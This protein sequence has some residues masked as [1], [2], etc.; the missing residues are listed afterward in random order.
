MKL[1][2]LVIMSVIAAS[3][4]VVPINASDL[5]SNGPTTLNNN[6]N[7][8]TGH[9]NGVS[10]PANPSV[11]SIPIIT[12]A[13]GVTYTGLPN[14]AVALTYSTATHSFSCPSSVTPSAHAA[15]HAAAGSDPLSLDTSQIISG[16]FGAA[17]LPPCG[18]S[19]GSHAAGLIPDPGASGGTTRF[20]REDCT[21]VVINTGNAGQLQGRTLASTAPTNHQAVGWNN[22]A[23]QWEPMTLAPADIGLGS[24]T[25]DVQTKAAVL[26]NTL[27]ST[28]QI[29]VGNTGGTAYVPKTMSGDG[30]LDNNGTLAVLKVGGKAVTPS[31][32]LQGGTPALSGWGIVEMAG[33][34]VT[35]SGNLLSAASN[36]IEITGTLPTS[37]AGTYEFLPGTKLQETTTATFS[38]GSVAK[39]R[40]CMGRAGQSSTCEITP[41]LILA[42]SL[43]NGARSFPASPV[44]GAT[45]MGLALSFSCYDSSDV[46][47]NCGNGSGTSF[48]TAGAIKWTVAGYPNVQ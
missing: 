46:L 22:G 25:N 12:V 5:V 8:L 20:L 39:L 45:T 19:G 36:T 3:A 24:V 30:T 35:L 21:W 32:S 47:T 2:V 1:A 31:T 29:P 15:S 6:F 14:C 33:D 27:P 48:V 16:V 42:Q 4:Q 37:I 43:P 13:N 9:V 40:V 10:Y 44:F 23:N 28:G 7:W 26:P 11:D 34:T 38:G 41:Q 17:R 18:P